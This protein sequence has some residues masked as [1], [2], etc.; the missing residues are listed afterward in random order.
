MVAGRLHYGAKPD[1]EYSG[2]KR[3]MA[4]CA[5]HHLIRGAPRDVGSTVG[6]VRRQR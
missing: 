1:Q 4:A 6:A 2:D 3:S 5:R